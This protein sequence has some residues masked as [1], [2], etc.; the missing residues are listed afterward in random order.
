MAKG[1]MSPEVICAA[2]QEH[3]A[4]AEVTGERLNG[5]LLA[6]R[7]GCGRT[8]LYTNP[9]IRGLLLSA[10]IIDDIP[11]QQANET[12]RES[13]PYDTK[14]QSAAERRLRKA[15]DRANRLELLL[16]VR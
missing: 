13:T 7:I 16:E 4:R 9:E 12:A 15:E 11:S 2:V 6:R 10:G 5:T 8:V 1:R 14:E 3:L